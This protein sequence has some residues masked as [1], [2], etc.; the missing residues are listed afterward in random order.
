VFYS[1]Q[2]DDTDRRQNSA[3]GEIHGR[4]KTH[5]APAFSVC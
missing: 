2:G 5:V 1:R 4:R 3:A